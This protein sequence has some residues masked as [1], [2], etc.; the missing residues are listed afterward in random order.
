MG[1]SRTCSRT[2]R[3]S[4]V[5]LSGAPVACGGELL[6][7]GD[8]VGK[9]HAAARQAAFVPTVF[10]TTAPFSD[11]PARL[12]SWANVVLAERA[13]QDPGFVTVACV[14]LSP[15][16]RGLRWGY[17]GHPAALCLDTG[18]ELGGTKSTPRNLRAPR[19]HLDDPRSRARHRRA[20]LHRRSHRG[21]PPRRAIRPH[22]PR[23]NG[24]RPATTE[25]FPH[26]RSAHRRD[27]S[28]RRHAASPPTRSPSRAS[29]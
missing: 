16:E 1:R 2:S 3:R 28:I 17:A 29:F 11:D 14:V 21:A 7:V 22:P 15:R 24:P 6:V 5:T 27:P 13:E 20:A 23:Q 19:L 4:R 26:R 8:V 25:P 18:E 9:G 12:L 10:A